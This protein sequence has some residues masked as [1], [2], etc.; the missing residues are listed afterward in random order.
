MSEKSTT[1]IDEN[2]SVVDT[3]EEGL[4]YMQL[5]E[6]YDIKVVLFEW[7]VISSILD[8]Y[9]TLQTT[10]FCSINYQTYIPF[11]LLKFAFKLRPLV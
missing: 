4:K 6:F 1:D 3:Q 2:P 9:Y 5:E 8:P 10:K 7:W 11:F